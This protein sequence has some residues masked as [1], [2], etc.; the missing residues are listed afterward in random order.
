L[1]PASCCCLARFALNLED[2]DAFLQKNYDFRQ[3]AWRHIPGIELLFTV[4]VT[5]C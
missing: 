4:I 5:S 3:T 2:G 1:L